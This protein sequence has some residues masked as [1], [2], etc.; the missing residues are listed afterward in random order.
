MKTEATEIG[1]Y[2]SENEKY[3]P[4]AKAGDEEATAKLM[5]LNS[6]LVSGIARRFIGRGIDIED[7]IQIGSIGML[8]AIRSFDTERGTQF[9][10]YA[11]PLIIG[12]IRKYLRDDGMI[13]VSRL[14]KRTGAI[15]IREAEKF[16]MIHSREPQINELAAL[17]GI[18]VCEAVDALNSVSV[19]HSF[20]EALNDD[21]DFTLEQTLSSTDT[22]IDAKTEQI[23]LCQAI[24]KLPPMWRKIIILRYYREYSQQETADALGLSQVKISREEKKIYA[25]LKEELG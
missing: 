6:G 25:A 21:G 5:E 23:A 13:K 22:G 24:G 19:V 10:T 8:K 7:L 15:L 3:I 4:L 12:E 1:K 14:K 11:V 17:C 18:D 20:S 2:K 16:R 9:S